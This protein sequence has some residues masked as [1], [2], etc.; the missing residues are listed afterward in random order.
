M[1]GDGIVTEV[2][3]I[4]MRVCSRRLKCR[5]YSDE[6]RDLVGSMSDER[7]DCNERLRVERLKAELSSAMRHDADIRSEARIS[8]MSAELQCTQC[9]VARAHAMHI[10]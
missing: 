6:D 9:V 4:D 5:D 8:A 1:R 3:E 2:S 7:I 10:F